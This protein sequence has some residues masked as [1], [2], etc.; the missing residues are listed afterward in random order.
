ME[1]PRIPSL[2]TSYAWTPRVRM[3]GRV[4][5]AL[6]ALA[7]ITLGSLA[8]ASRLDPEGSDLIRND[9]TQDYV[10]ARAW[11]H[12]D[13][14][15]RP[16]SHLVARYLGVESSTTVTA[17]GEQ[18]NPHTP[19]AVVIAR[20][21]SALPYDIARAGWMIMSAVMFVVALALVGREIGWSLVR[22][23]SVAMGAL[24]LPVVQLDLTYV[25]WNAP[26]MLLIVLGWRMLRRGK[27]L[28]AGLLFGIAAAIKLYPA[29]L[30]LVVLA[31]R[32]WRA[33][34]GMVAMATIVTGWG[35]AALGTEASKRFLD[36]ASNNF[37]YWRSAP[38][39]LSIL[40][41]PYRWLS[42][43]VWR[44]D[45]PHLPLL[46]AVLSIGILAAGASLVYRSPARASGDPVL[47]ALPWMVL[48]APL[49]WPLTPVLTIPTLVVLLAR[50]HSERGM[51]DL[52]LV[53]AIAVIVAPLPGLPHGAGTPIM[54]LIF[55]HGLPTIALLVVA[56]REWRRSRSAG[57]KVVDLV[58]R[59]RHAPAPALP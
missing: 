4:L 29:I 34:G 35:M 9:F 44:P 28:P 52:I 19:A 32:R 25:Q 49:S 45:A 10:S 56:A 39:N 48:L 27:D 57:D 47:A 8:V 5:L 51:P 22:S 14:P 36:V 55:G 23:L 46:A 15:Y 54:T 58:D 17:L 21:L 53:V 41:A 26:M 40:A 33:A 42:E 24:A 59:A 13:D 12:G 20:P 18:P 6:S 2:S 50:S 7:A 3:A 43:S 37:E 31:M 38:M 11:A 30:I 16:T 1:M